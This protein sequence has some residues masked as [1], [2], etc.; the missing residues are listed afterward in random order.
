MK[1][2]FSL[3]LRIL[4]AGA[5]TILGALLL[6]AFGLSVL[7]ER[8]VERRI[9][10][11]LNDHLQQ[12]IAGFECCRAG[13]PSMARPPADPRFERPLSGLYWQ[14]GAHQATLRSRSLWDA[15]LEPPL[16]QLS[17]GAR[18]QHRIQGPDGRALLALEQSLLLSQDLGGGMMRAVVAVDATEARA[19]TAAFAND[20]LPSLALLGVLLMAANGLQVWLGLRPLRAIGQKLTA[21]GEGRLRR[22]GDDL[23]EEVLP[24][25]TEV[26]A[27]LEARELAISRAQGR[28]ADLAHGLRTPIQVFLGDAAALQQRGDIA[29]ARRIEEVA[30]AMRRHVE[31]EL[32]R[33]RRAATSVPAHCD[34]KTVASRVLAVLQRTPA[35]ARLQWELDVPDGLCGRM[36]QDDLAEALG[37]LAENAAKHA[38]SLV[39]IQARP[40]ADGIVISVADD[41]PGI[42]T[43]RLQEAL[44]RGSRLDE[45]GDGAGLGLA[46]VQNIAETW[47]VAFT[48]R[49]TTQGLRVEFTLPMG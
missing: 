46:I 13:G 29:S 40:G 19:A 20:L 28:A 39:A 8:H 26:D 3:R 37:N 11:E 36:D 34:I 47:G 17:D 23:P 41:G 4:L 2:P 44:R 43:D 42:P 1:K 14:V 25:A 31:R 7:F 18:H 27:L 24:L 10:A 22:L 21:I 48:L 33:A 32:T 12:V 9:V 35:G 5:L 30:L 16:D 49:N 45:R 6:A 15:V 38:S